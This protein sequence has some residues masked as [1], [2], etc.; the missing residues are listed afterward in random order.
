MKLLFK[1]GENKLVHCVADSLYILN[2]DRKDYEKDNTAVLYYDVNGCAVCLG[3]VHKNSIE[4]LSPEFV[5][6]KFQ[7]YKNNMMSALNQESF[8][9]SH[10]VYTSDF[11]YLN[12]LYGIDLEKFESFK[13]YYEK[14][15]EEQ[16]KEREDRYN[17][18]LEAERLAEIERVQKIKENIIKNEYVSGRDVLDVMNILDISCPL[19]TKGLINRCDKINNIDAVINGKKP[20]ES[21]INNLFKYFK[22]VQNY[23]IECDEYDK[24][25]P[26][27]REEIE[28]L[29][30]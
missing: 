5:E 26:E 1:R 29:F 27:E 20:S 2:K 23:L 15:L 25:N 28:A 4:T 19:R 8:N 18:N 17:A 16:K 11:S 14:H 13:N 6:S 3:Y 9:A 22:I 30:K 10:E 7:I 12:A 21:S 24:L